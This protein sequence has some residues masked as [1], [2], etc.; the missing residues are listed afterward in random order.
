[1]MSKISKRDGSNEESGKRN[2]SSSGERSGESNGKQGKITSSTRLP[3]FTSQAQTAA[4]KSG[5][6][7][8]RG[9]D[10]KG[11]KTAQDEENGGTYLRLNKDQ[12]ADISYPSTSKKTSR[13]R[14]RNRSKEAKTE[15]YQGVGTLIKPLTVNNVFDNES[16]ELIMVSNKIINKKRSKKK[17]YNPYNDPNFDPN[18]AQ[19][20]NT[21]FRAHSQTSVYNTSPALTQ[22]HIDVH[23]NTVL[24]KIEESLE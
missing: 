22:M 12:T 20:R 23:S 15:K 6:H 21:E 11:G 2:N 4:T 18:G 7:S 1:M 13:S 9:M 16:D 17:R 14:E 24:E 19:Y 3:V 10:D 5:Y 8:Q